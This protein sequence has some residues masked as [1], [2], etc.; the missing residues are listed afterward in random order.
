M[1]VMICNGVAVKPGRLASG[2][3]LAESPIKG[4]PFGFSGQ[5]VLTRAYPN[6]YSTLGAPQTGAPVRYDPHPM[7]THRDTATL[8]IQAHT[9]SWNTKL[10]PPDRAIEIAPYERGSF[11]TRKPFKLVQRTNQARKEN[12]D[13]PFK[14]GP[15]R[16]PLILHMGRPAPD[17]S[18]GTHTFPSFFTT[19]TRLHADPNR[20]QMRPGTKGAGRW[21]EIKRGAAG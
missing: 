16:T 6:N 17:H 15:K 7:E 4:D 11:Q 13:T 3:Y 18:R 21:D 1:P 9:V 12:P 2:A 10:Y 5:P 8:Q 20:T 19:H 14:P